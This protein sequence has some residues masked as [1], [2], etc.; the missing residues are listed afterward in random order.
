MVWYCV[1]SEWTGYFG[2]SGEGGR[3]GGGVC[4]AEAI[5]NTVM[6]REVFPV[7]VTDDKH[8]LTSTLAS[9]DYYT[10]LL[11]HNAIQYHIEDNTSVAFLLFVFSHRR[12]QCLCVCVY[13]HV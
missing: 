12:I 13:V 11:R 3:G 2:G 1:A 7:P 9:G 4:V 8:L 6:W 10:H 5:F